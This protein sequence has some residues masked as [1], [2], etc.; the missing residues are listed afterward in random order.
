MIKTPPKIIKMVYYREAT[1]G[2]PIGEFPLDEDSK[3]VIS[4][5]HEWW[6][7][8]QKMA[9]FLHTVFES[10]D[11]N[12]ITAAA[13]VVT[14][15][16]KYMGMSYKPLEYYSQ[17]WAGPGEPFTISLALLFRFGQLGL[18][19]AFAEVIEPTFKIINRTIPIFASESN[20]GT[21]VFGPGPRPLEI[22][23]TIG[24]EITRFQSVLPGNGSPAKELL[25]LESKNKQQQIAYKRFKD[26]V[27]SHINEG[28]ISLE[29]YEEMKILKDQN[30]ETKEYYQAYITLHSLEEAHARNQE[31]YVKEVERLFDANNTPTYQVPRT[32][33]LTFGGYVFKHLVCKTASFTF[34]PE[35]DEQGFPIRSTV[36]LSFQ[37]YLIALANTIGKPRTGV[38]LTKDGEDKKIEYGWSD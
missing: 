23:S 35:I 13:S 15:V 18:Y 2:V 5:S 29:E 10:M 24:T 19:N 37:P 11:V 20:K 30:S 21:K 26:L 9:E 12:Y 25:K 28:G 34:D 7:P 3:N 22:L 17:A 36:T 31:E 14:E 33:E 6:Q 38:V 16:P 32:W 8:V 1:V 27:A 4:F